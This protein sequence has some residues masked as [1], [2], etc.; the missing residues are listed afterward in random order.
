MG[1]MMS[2]TFSMGVH[3][4]CFLRRKVHKNNCQLLCTGISL[5]TISGNICTNLF[6]RSGIPVTINEGH[7]VYYT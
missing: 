5:N 6:K 7:K 3:F 2:M 4:I 1:R